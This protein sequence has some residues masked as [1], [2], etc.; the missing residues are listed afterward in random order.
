MT[1]KFTSELE[2]SG[3]TSCC[4]CFSEAEDEL[5]V[6]HHYLQ[7]DFPKLDVSACQCSDLITSH[8]GTA[9]DFSIHLRQWEERAFR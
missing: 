2:S 5:W 3:W 1:S 6:I 9:L 7:R 4:T 8:P